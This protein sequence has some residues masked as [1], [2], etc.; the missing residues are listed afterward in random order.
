V[1]AFAYDIGPSGQ[2]VRLAD[3]P[4]VAPKAVA[5]ARQTCGQEGGGALCLPRRVERHP[6]LAALARVLN[7]PTQAGSAWGPDLVRL[8]RVLSQPALD[9]ARIEFRLQ[10]F[11]R[12]APLMRALA[13][14]YMTLARQL[15]GT[16]GKNPVA[17]AWVEERLR[18]LNPWYSAADGV[19]L[20]TRLTT[21]VEITPVILDLISR[22]LYGSPL[23]RDDEAEAEALYLADAWPTTELAFL[24]ALPAVVER[25]RSAKSRRER[26]EA[27][28]RRGVRLG[29]HAEDGT[30]VILEDAARAQHLYMIGGT[31]TG[32]ST[33]M[34]NMIAQDMQAGEAIM[35][36]DPHGSLVED[37]LRL[38]PKKRRQDVLYLHPTDPKG[39]FTLNLLEPIGTDVAV[40]RNRCANDLIALMKIVYPEPPEAYGPMFQNYFR[41]A[42]FL[43]LAGREDKAVLGEVR[44]VFADDSFREQLTRACPDAGVKMFWSRIAARIE[45]SGEN[46]SIDNVAPY[47]DAK[48][49]QLSGN[50]VIERII[51]TPKSSV[52]FRQIAADKRICLV[53]LAQGLIGDEDA[54]LLGGM[55]FGRLSAYL[56]LHAMTHI[57]RSRKGTAAATRLSR[58]VPVLRR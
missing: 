22:C 47:V 36:I 35:V 51:G 26:V 38:V 45:H 23:A 4:V 56:K 30:P 7:I 43:V 6:E 28:S 5:G 17:R 46:A 8:A 11:T 18:A 12:G 27:A 49:T 15:D 21:R 44:R 37:V 13:D 48:L 39:A 10:R 55:L 53:N 42:V 24:Q 31:G 33:L 25:H 54:R 9:G 50:P 29:S 32:K 20:K 57:G 14:L 3:M 41:N 58:R 19:R 52:D 2:M 16:G 40:E 34:A 1:S